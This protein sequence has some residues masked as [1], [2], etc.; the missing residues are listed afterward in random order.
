LLGQDDAEAKKIMSEVTSMSAVPDE[1]RPF[2]AV[3]SYEGMLVNQHLGEADRVY[4]FRET[5]NG[6]RLVEQRKTPPAGTGNARWETLGKMLDDCRALLV[7]GIGPSPSAS[8]AQR[9]PDYRNDRLD[10]RRP[11]CCLQRQGIANREKGRRFQMRRLLLRES[12]R[13]LKGE[14]PSKSP[15]R[16]RL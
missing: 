15:R 5:P 13:V 7:G 9:H 11:G 6:Y 10:R 2:V 12:K 1:T 8:S 3:A 14:S 16:G 4:V